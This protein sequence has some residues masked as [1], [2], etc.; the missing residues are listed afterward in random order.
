MFVP[1]RMW[2]ASRIIR[3]MTVLVGFVVNVSVCVFLR[4]MRMFMFVVFRHM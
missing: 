3:P 2:L 4:L 1:M